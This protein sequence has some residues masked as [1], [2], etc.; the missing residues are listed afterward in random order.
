[1]IKFIPLGGAGEIGANCYYL[2]IE[3]TG[4]LLDCGMHPQKSGLDSLPNFDLIKDLPVDYVLISHAHMDHINSLPYLVQRHPYIKIIT[5][6]QTRAIAELTLHNS[7]SIFRE[8]LGDHSYMKLYSHEEI[9][10]LIQS[11]EYR[12]YEEVFELK[13]YNGLKI[14]KASFHG[15]GH[16]LGSA[17]ILIDTGEERLFYTG[18]IKLSSQSLIDKA[19]LPKTKID[20]LLLETTYGS[21]D[22]RAI[23]SWSMEANT[24]ISNGGSI[25]IPVFSL[26]KHQEILATVWNL[27]QKGTLT[28]TDIYTG[29]IGTKINTVYDYNRY[30][31]NMLDKEFVL[32]NISQKNLYDITNYEEFFK[33]P[34]I[35]LASSGMMLESTASYNLAKHWLKN[36]RSAIF[37][38]GY[39]EKNTPGYKIANASK[40]D[41]IRLSELSESEIVKCQIQCFRFPSHAFREDLIEIVNKLNPGKVILVH[42]DPLSIDWV[43]EHILKEFR[44]IKVF[45]AEAG[46]ELIL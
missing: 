3:G 32:K 38:V 6:P 21:T 18:D 16:I 25:L 30:N 8:Q 9:D 35:V 44:H 4:I 37:T 36:P 17:G 29:G 34:S 23:L 15:A 31:V 28:E 13:G 11:I 1:M 42:G 45:S 10:L 19:R 33:S 5:T 24:I 41:Q 43:G 7:V 14:I 39:M 26:G 22:T 27:M 2:G 20:L 46:K 40:G 12:S